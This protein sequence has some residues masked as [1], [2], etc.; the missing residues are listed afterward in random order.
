MKVQT[1]VEHFENKMSTVYFQGVRNMFARESVV[2]IVLDASMFG[3]RDYQVHIAFAPRGNFAGCLP[4]TMVRH[5]HWR[6][7]YAGLPIT[8]V[9]QKNFQATGF[10]ARKGQTIEDSIRLWHHVLKIACTGG[11]G[12]LKFKCPVDFKP[13]ASGETRMWSQAKQCWL[14]TP[15]T[16][17]S[18]VMKDST[19][20]PEEPY[21]ELPDSMQSVEKICALL[22]TVDQKQ[23]Q[24]S[25]GQ[26][27]NSAGFMIW[28]R[29]DCFHRSWRDFV[30]A[31]E[32]AEGGFHH[33][34]A[35]LTHCFG[36]NYQAMGMHMA[37]RRELQAEW[38]QL[39]P[40]YGPDFEELCAMVSLDERKIGCDSLTPS[41]SDFFI[42]LHSP[43][44]EVA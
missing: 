9:D 11:E 20:N 42:M 2:E 7:A 43:L 32:V 6:S 14:R 37:K 44:H 24:W 39:L 33:T 23:C 1:N 26:Y 19:T 40:R 15:C 13:V 18:G 35:Q 10:Q 4:P 3:T 38:R 31:M 41:S 30:R 29:E 8:E 27:L 12:L 36:V 22:A 34:C 21:P 5:L 28:M 25:A 17:T 16:P